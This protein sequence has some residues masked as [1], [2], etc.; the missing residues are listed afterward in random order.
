[1]SAEGC[2]R[3]ER[4]LTGQDYHKSAADNL[5]AACD[6]A[7]ALPLFR[8]LEA[9]RMWLLYQGFKSRCPAPQLLAWVQYSYARVL[10]NLYK[11][12]SLPRALVSV[13]IPYSQAVT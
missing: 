11:V 7:T 9:R 10:A 2:A 4:Q 6:L 8:K 5:L 13:H 3:L 1:M 12:Q